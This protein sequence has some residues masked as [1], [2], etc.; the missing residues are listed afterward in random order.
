MSY[1]CK[2]LAMVQLLLFLAVYC[3]VS[4]ESGARADDLN[5]TLHLL[6]LV[7]L[8]ETA[9]PS[10]QLPCHRGEELISAAQLAVD[11][12][13][14][15]DDILPDYKLELVPANTETCNQSLVTE[16][17]GN[18][19]RHVTGDL[20]IVGVVGLV[21]STVTQAVSP[22]AG[23]PGIG[24]LHISA[25]AISPVFT[26]EE[27][28]PHL[29]RMIP[30][31]AVYNDAVLELMTTFQ[32]RRISM[33]QDTI[34]IQHTTTADD[35]VTK[36][37]GRNESELVFLGEVSPTFPTS[38]VK[39]LLPKA[40]KIIYASVTATEARELLCESYQRDL[41]WPEF[42]WLFHDL[43][44]EEL[45][46]STENCSNETMLR[47]VEGVFLLQYRLQPN[48]NTM[49]VSG[50]TYSEYLME[51][52][53]RTGQEGIP[54]Q[55]DDSQQPLYAG[56][57]MYAKCCQHA[58]ALH[59]SIWAFALALNNLT[60][61][62]FGSVSELDKSNVTT[63][64]ERNLKAVQFSGA[65]GDIAFNDER[66]VVTIVN[67]FHVQE[68]K[69]IYVGHYN[70]FTGNVTVLNQLSEIP[71]DDFEERRDDLPLGLLITTLALAAVLFVF[72]TVVLALLVYY[73]NK[74][75]IKATSPGLAV[76]I[77]VGCC[78]L[79]MGCLFGGAREPIDYKY[80]DSLCQA[81]LWFCVIGLQMIYSALFMRL[82]R[83]YR[84]FF[85][86]FKK[87]GI[88]WS[89]TAMFAFTFIPVSV[90]ILAMT[91]WSVLDPLFTIVSRHF[92]S[93]HRPPHY[94]VRV[95]C[96][97]NTVELW[98]SIILYGINGVIVLAVVV[99]A[100]LTRKV[101]LECFKDTK[102]VN[103]FVCSTVLCLC[104]WVPFLY[105]HTLNAEDRIAVASYIISVYPYFVIPF[106][107]KVFLFIPKIW[108]ARH[109][110]RRRPTKKRPSTLHLSIA[111]R[112]SHMISWNNPSS[113]QSSFKIKPNEHT[114]WSRNIQ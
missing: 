77:L 88:L 52:H 98:L 39:N 54:F 31:S 34:L 106:L 79:Y 19:V 9:G 89:N 108:S 33:V 4:A 62:E 27:E 87:P 18:F 50:Q 51:L 14:M 81:Q 30:S 103:I 49:L 20:N 93:T 73:W 114:R 90:A 86:V 94:I 78:M 59:D 85:F 99:L 105:T 46:E 101:H 42:V 55:P 110:K 113:L 58:N 21:C 45:T 84:L 32:W 36:I 69:V 3:S 24:L 95:T 60:S 29:Y 47:A 63:L 43:S 2:T 72:T 57:E 91:L 26:S 37:E 76:L 82:L 68:G 66:E 16:A 96:L 74:P 70:P 12:I 15:R 100:I 56:P 40:A 10:H 107:C 48:P 22:L 65:L 109:E 104:T 1:V 67:I 5:A 35:F 38:P 6:T 11:K 17:L 64:V 92:D 25:G 53:N 75:S 80:F 97:S 7:P 23:R 111:R 28:Y 44:F 102:H 83:I 41:R 61:A 8:A 112:S 71:K 13:N